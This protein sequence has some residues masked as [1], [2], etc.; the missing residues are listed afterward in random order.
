MI[1][2]VRSFSLFTAYQFL[3]PAN[4]DFCSWKQN[5]TISIMC[6]LTALRLHDGDDRDEFFLWLLRIKFW[7]LILFRIGL[8]KDAILS[9]NT[10]PADEESALCSAWPHSYHLFSGG[11]PHIGVG[12]FLLCSL[13]ISSLPA[14]QIPSAS[15]VWKQ[16]HISIIRRSDLTTSLTINRS[17]VHGD[18]MSREYEKA[19][20]A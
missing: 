11:W 2:A 17:G 16:D 13:Y 12:V 3:S 8:D 14:G 15:T 6:V 20:F 10:T 1:A 19:V 7:V 18:K 4:L 9:Y 5:A